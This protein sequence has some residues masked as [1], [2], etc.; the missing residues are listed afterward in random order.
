MFKIEGLDELQKK[1]GDLAKGAE[2]LDGQHS[3]PVSELLT[4]AFISQHTSFSSADE[5]LKVSGFKIETQEDFAAIPDAAWDNFIRSISRFDGWQ[6][7]LGA[8]RQEYIKRQLG[9]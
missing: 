2:A 4:D 6:S 5:M 1:L 9:L 7:I 8:A 3:V